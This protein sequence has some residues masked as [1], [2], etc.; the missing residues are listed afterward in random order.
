M[1]DDDEATGDEDAEG[2]GGAGGGAQRDDADEDLDEDEDED[3]QVGNDEQVVWDRE[4]RAME[5][6]L[7]AR[8][9]KAKWVQ[10]DRV[11][12]AWTADR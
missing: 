1:Y 6:E 3:A 12:W 10:R 8:R 4:D 2:A 5:K 11:R 7:E 9:R